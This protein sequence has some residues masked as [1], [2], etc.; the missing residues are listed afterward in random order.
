METG[1]ALLP[2]LS[3]QASVN[4]YFFLYHR[5]ENKKQGQHLTDLKRAQT[6][7]SG[8]HVLRKQTVATFFWTTIFIYWLFLKHFRPI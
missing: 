1:T 3:Q 5:Q 6:A 8:G 4:N 7:V 2:P